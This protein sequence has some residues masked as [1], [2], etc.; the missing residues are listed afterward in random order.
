ME[1]I[2]EKLNCIDKDMKKLFIE[3]M[4]LIKEI[5]LYKKKHHLEIEDIKRERTMME[6]IDIENPVIKDLY[7]KFLNEVISIS[8]LYQ[9]IIIEE[10][11]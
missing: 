10:E 9:E 2:R 5:A 3:R 4:I 11:V 7:V 1:E 8:K 6:N